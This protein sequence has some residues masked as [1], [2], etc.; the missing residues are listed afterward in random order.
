MSK[1]GE[2]ISRNEERIRT[3]WINDMAKSV[4]RADLISKVELEEQTRSLL[5]AIAKGASSEPVR[6]YYQ[7]AM[8]YR[9]RITARHIRHR[10][11]ARD[12]HLLRPRPLCFLSNSRFS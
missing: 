4:Q 9:P 6:R 3:D 10:A 12:L 7:S 11:R 5:S 8:E 1:L 2:I